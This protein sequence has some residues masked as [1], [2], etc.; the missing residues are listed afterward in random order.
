MTTF[1]HTEPTSL[2]ILQE[3]KL[4]QTFL[5]TSCKYNTPNSEMLMASVNAFGA[6]CL[7]PQG[8]EMFNK[9]KPLP[10]FFDL[11]T[12]HEFL[13]NATEVDNATALGSTMDELTRHHPSLKPSVFECVARMIRK[14]V[15]MGKSDIG[16][17]SDDSHLLKL[18]PD[19]T[20]S[21]NVG[22]S[23]TGGNDAAVP[24]TGSSSEDVEMATDNDAKSPIVADDN[25]KDDKPECLLVAFIDMVARVNIKISSIF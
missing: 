8:L 12:D 4:P 22:A 20:P 17:P 24:Q 18:M 25:K 5:D 3:A 6:I 11:L 23:A 15:E 1:I 21:G 10:H 14:V 13:R 7:N 16:K 9:A 19:T 2:P